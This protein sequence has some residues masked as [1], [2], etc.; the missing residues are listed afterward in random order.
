[1]DPESPEVRQVSLF[2]PKKMEELHLRPEI[3][4]GLTT[5]EKDNS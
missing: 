5:L 1:M 4:E 3:K 2:S